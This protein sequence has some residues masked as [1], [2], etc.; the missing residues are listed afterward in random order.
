[1]TLRSGSDAFR[2][3]LPV[4]GDTTG[5]RETTDKSGELYHAVLD[6]PVRYRGADIHQVI[7]RPARQGQAPHYGMRGFAVEIA[8]ITD[9]ALRTAEVIDPA[10]LDFVAVGEIDDASDSVPTAP[11]VADHTDKPADTGGS[12]DQPPPRPRAAAPAVARRARPNKKP[13]LIAA[14]AAA[15][16]AAGVATV[17]FT[18]SDDS[19]DRPAASAVDTPT[20]VVTPTATQART[21]APVE[22]PEAVLRL[23]PP[24]YKPGA[25]SPDPGVP[26]GALAAL[27][28]TRNSDS[29]GPES[30]H[31]ILFADGAALKAEF[32]R[33][34]ASSTTQVCPGRIMSPGP[35]RRNATPEVTAGILF[36][37]VRQEKSVIAWTDDAKVL[38][39][40]VDSAGQP[41]MEDMFKWW[42]THS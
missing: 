1:M 25:C 31:Y 4:G 41:G 42:S 35:W 34:V 27:S 38:L 11:P 32:D 21:I 18:Y 40:V 28:C 29:G 30:G 6:S 9:P 22:K 33:V 10:L 19:A 15:V 5:I 13:L 12:A 24:G 23:I 36:C 2:A 39:A 8:P 26:V 7:L 16:L 14:A 37:G 3:G 17:R 20:P